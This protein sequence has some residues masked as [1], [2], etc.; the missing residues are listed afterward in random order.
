MFRDCV[1]QLDKGKSNYPLCPKCEIPFDFSKLQIANTLSTVV[2]K[3][4]SLAQV[5]EEDGVKM[6]VVLETKDS[7]D[8]TM[9]VHKEE[10]VDPPSQTK[11]DLEKELEAVREEIKTIEALIASESDHVYSS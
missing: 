10:P 7:N 2:E 6:E 8:S 3:F 5:A 1:R 4:Q 11:E 9:M